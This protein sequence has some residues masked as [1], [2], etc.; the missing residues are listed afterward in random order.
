VTRVNV[1][2][3]QG[4]AHYTHLLMTCRQIHA[5]AASI[6][7]ANHFEVIAPSI[8]SPFQLQNRYVFPS[9]RVLT[10][11]DLIRNLR[12]TYRFGWRK[13]GKNWR[14]ITLD[15]MF[16][17]A[18]FPKMTSLSV[19]IT[20]YHHRGPLDI[21]N[22]SN[23]RSH[24]QFM[25]DL[26]P[27]AA[28]AV[29]STTPQDKLTSIAVRFQH[30]LESNTVQEFDF[31]DKAKIMWKGG[32]PWKEGRGYHDE[33]VGAIFNRV[34]ERLKDARGAKKVSEEAGSWR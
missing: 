26:T 31:P 7:Y 23:F 22:L 21:P 9:S 14:N 15:I 8:I 32:F 5:E 34:F 2:K 11:C 17:K 33:Y 12:L 27:A 10:Y 20:L 1:N 13:A 3:G 4:N 28:A 25:H 29:P 30:F 19:I 6:L 24:F 16:L 18:Q